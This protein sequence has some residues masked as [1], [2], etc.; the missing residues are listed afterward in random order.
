MTLCWGKEWN[1]RATEDR[2]ITNDLFLG[3]RK[4]T[5]ATE[6]RTE[7]QSSMTGETYQF[8][9]ICETNLA[10]FKK[11]KKK[12]ADKVEHL[13]DN[14]ILGVSLGQP[15]FIQAFWRSNFRRRANCSSRSSG[16]RTCSAGRPNM[17]AAIFTLG[18]AS[19]T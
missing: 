18:C 2:S 10:L 15:A 19:Q 4:G 3:P 9:N 8:N 5:D 1:G 16:C 14:I 6:D 12:T 17:C 7:D 13:N 11:A